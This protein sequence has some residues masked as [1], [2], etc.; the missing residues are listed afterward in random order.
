MSTII[1]ICN[2]EGNCRTG[3]EFSNSRNVN[4][5]F[6]NGAWKGLNFK[7]GK[8]DYEIREVYIMSFQDDMIQNMETIDEL[9][10]KGIRIVISCISNDPR[11][12]LEGQN[13]DDIKEYFKINQ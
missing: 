7:L 6:P 13:Y 2:S 10:K 5:I 4:A 9:A 11:L 12:N 8:F 1:R 3:F